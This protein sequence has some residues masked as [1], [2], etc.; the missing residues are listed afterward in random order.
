MYKM[1]M[2]QLHFKESSLW[3]ADHTKIFKIYPF[4]ITY[5]TLPNNEVN[6]IIKDFFGEKILQG[7]LSWSIEF[8]F[9]K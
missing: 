4:L 1:F 5:C 8:N 3:K 2:S 9:L 7:V 6:P